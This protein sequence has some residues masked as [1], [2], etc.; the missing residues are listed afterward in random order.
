MN[1]FYVYCIYDS[2]DLIKKICYIESTANRLKKFYEKN[3]IEYGQWYVKKLKAIYNENILYLPGNKEVLEEP[4]EED[5]IEQN[6]LDRK[7]EDLENFDNL[8]DKLIDLPNIS[9]TETNLLFKIKK[10]I[11]KL[12]E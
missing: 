9:P 2:N 5:I 11:S 3:D 10:N 6:R 12:Y 7:K 1:E 4:T 8:F